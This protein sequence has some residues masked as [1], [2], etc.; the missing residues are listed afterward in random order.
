MLGYAIIKFKSHLYLFASDS[1]TLQLLQSKNEYLLF[2]LCSEK[3][4]IFKNCI[5]PNGE[6]RIVVIDVSK[7]FDRVWYIGLQSWKIIVFLAERFISVL[8]NRIMEIELND[9]WSISFYI[10]TDSPQGSTLRP[11]LFL[12]FVN[13]LRDQFLTQY[14]CWGHNYLLIGKFEVG[15]L[16]Q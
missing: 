16:F 7:T 9:D 10:D 1:V 15:R 3:K 12:I 11:T 5:K 8:P 13:Y 2:I 4:I 6:V 14:L